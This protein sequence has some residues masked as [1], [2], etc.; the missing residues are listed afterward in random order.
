MA[1]YTWDFGSDAEGLKFSVVYD[2]DTGAFTI[3][4]LTGALNVN[5]LYWSDG[6]NV[7]SIDTALSGFTGAKSESSLNMNGTGE[8][9]DG[10]L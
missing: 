3:T 5:A 6:D 4:V 1:A 8:V 7:N 10:G 2:S 9:F